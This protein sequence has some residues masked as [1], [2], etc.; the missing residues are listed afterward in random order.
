MQPTI[1][2]AHEHRI[3]L[4][5]LISAATQPE[6]WQYAYSRLALKPIS[7]AVAY[8]TPCS[9]S[10]QKTLTLPPA[11]PQNRFAMNFATH[12]LLVVALSWCT[13]ILG[14]ELIEVATFR[15]NHFKMMNRTIATSHH[16]T[17]VAEFYADNVYG[18]I[19]DDAQ[20]RDF[21]I[22][23]LYF[24]VSNEKILDYS[25]GFADTKRRLIRLIG[26]PEQRYL[27][28]PVR[29]LRAIRFAAKLGSTLKMTRAEPVRRL[30]HLLRDIPA[31]RLYE[32]VLKLFLS[33]YAVRTYELL[34]QYHFLRTT[35]PSQPPKR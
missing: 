32:E 30:A 1:L 27:E 31:A 8:A 2:D 11:R 18:N 17:P 6:C 21:T 16:T 12:A 24:D 7:W 19:E 10:R 9:E 13:C 26:D 22:N 34:R 20:R 23:A 14:R 5:T 29:M 25:T 3:E 15:S 4:L 28:D 33:G 35:V